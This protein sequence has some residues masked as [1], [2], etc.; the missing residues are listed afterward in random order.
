M[1]AEGRS[2]RLFWPGVVWPGVVFRLVVIGGLVVFA[3]TAGAE[4]PPKPVAPICVIDS[5]PGAASAHLERPKRS[6]N[7]AGQI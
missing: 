5:W 1:L 7:F 3:A 6:S 2:W 4:W